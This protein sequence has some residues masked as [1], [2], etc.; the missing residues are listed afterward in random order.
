VSIEFP[1]P[2]SPSS[3]RLTPTLKRGSYEL[4]AF[5]SA[6]KN[7]KTV[8]F[9]LCTLGLTL[10]SASHG[11]L[12]L[13]TGMGVGT[14]WGVYH[15]P[16]WRKG[17]NWPLLQQS[18]QGNNR[19]LV[20]A[21]ASGGIATLLTYIAA[22]AWTET[23]NRWLVMAILLQSLGTSALLGWLLLQGWNQKKNQ[24]KTSF[25]TLV[26]D[27]TASDP[28]K[29]LIAIRSL[30]HLQENAPLTEHQKEQLQEYFTL[31]VT[32]EPEIKVRLALLEALQQTK[33]SQI[34]L[35]P[36]KQKESAQISV[37]E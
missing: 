29:R 15:W 9:A 8:L 2:K 23:E 30:S 3:L 24:L 20:L 26:R 32:S 10:M 18:L 27:L 11:K 34:L 22:L 5:L 14:M 12:I 37:L 35:Q 25:E 21:V 28:L 4:I 6:K 17:L 1:W 13:A 16:K 33:Q 36:I 7:Q 19:N 31:M